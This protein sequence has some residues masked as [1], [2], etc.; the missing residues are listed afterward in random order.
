MEGVT[1]SAA[2][3]ENAPSELQNNT[4]APVA[5]TGESNTAAA[6]GNPQ[7]PLSKNAAKRLRKKLEW[8]NG[9]EDRRKQRKE[10]RQAQRIRKRDE[11]ASLIAQGIDPFANIPKR[12]TSTNVPLSLIFDCGF[13]E[14]MLDKELVSLGAQITRSYSENKNAV[15]RSHMWVSGWD[16]KLAARFRT[17]L[18]DKHRNWKGIEFLECDF[19]E[20]AEEYKD[21]VYLSSD[22]PYTLDR[23]EPNTSYVIGGLVDKNREKGLCYKRAR[24]LGIRTARL[25]IGEYM[26]MQSRTVLATNHVVEIMLKWLEFEDW[27]EAFLSVIP[28]RKGGQLRKQDGAEDEDEGPNEA[29]E[30]DAREAEGAE[31]DEVAPKAEAEGETIVKSEATVKSENL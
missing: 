29:E 13:E 19:I 14:Y 25:P 26:V 20:C 27:G 22:S 1:A 15:F 4:L 28:K 7:P 23:L 11:R 9:L 17:V 10:K 2:Q 8:E 3:S 6:E 18:E 30:D 12:P 31:G 24:E 5:L 16:G 21:I